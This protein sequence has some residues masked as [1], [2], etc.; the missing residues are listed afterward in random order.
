MEQDNL[1]VITKKLQE[2]DLNTNPILCAEYRAV[3]SG[4]YSFYAGHL[5]E[6]MKYKPVAWNAKRPEF[7]SDTACER[8]WQATEYGI[9]ETGINLKLKRIEKMMQGLNSLLKVAEGQSNNQY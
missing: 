6:I 9:N 1:A 7:K 5:E 2:G 3:L 8:W 4:E